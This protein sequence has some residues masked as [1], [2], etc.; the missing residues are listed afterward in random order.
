MRVK[1]VMMCLS[2]AMVP[3]LQL[4]CAVDTVAGGSSSDLPNGITVA[5]VNGVVEGTT[6]PGA[7]VAAYSA[8]YDPAPFV[9]ETGGSGPDHADTT[10]ADSAGAFLFSGLPQSDYNLLVR[11]TASGKALFVK[12][13]P[14]HRD[15]VFK[16]E[17]DTMYGPGALRGVAVDNSEIPVAWGWVV[18]D[19]SPFFD[20]TDS[21]GNFSIPD[22]PPADYAIQILS[23]MVAI[24]YPVL[25]R[26]DTVTVAPDTTTE[27]EP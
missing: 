11:D 25:V 4:A 24:P 26:I 13:I 3:V 20:E 12:G 5:S 6:R 16:T 2:C 21:A 27:W 22:M 15:S 17:I 14:V 23:D 19:G 10:Y 9:D 7:L 18:I 8:D 1:T